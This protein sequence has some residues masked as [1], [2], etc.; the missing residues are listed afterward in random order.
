MDQLL[1]MTAMAMQWLQIRDPNS[2]TSIGACTV[3]V[4]NDLSG[5][6][7]C[8]PVFWCLLLSDFLMLEQIISTIGKTMLWTQLGRAWGQLNEAPLEDCKKGSWSCKRQFSREC[9]IVPLNLR[10]RPMKVTSLLGRWLLSASGQHNR[11]ASGV[12]PI[13]FIH[14][15]IQCPGGIGIKHT[16]VMNML[17]DIL[18]TEFTGSHL[19]PT[20]VTKGR[21]GRYTIHSPGAVARQ[22]HAAHLDLWE[23][24]A[25]PHPPGLHFNPEKTL[26]L[27]TSLHIHADWI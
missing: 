20:C 27:C 25:H 12:K 10:P 7:M 13:H 4:Q 2:D 16:L 24:E 11:W 9:Y 18:R 6:N 26:S 21:R 17:R 15:C 3:T 5:C 19:G 8:N 22:S 23:S 1:S 14:F